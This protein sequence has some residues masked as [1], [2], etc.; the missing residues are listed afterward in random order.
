[1]RSFLPWRVTWVSSRLLAGTLLFLPGWVLAQEAAEKGATTEPDTSDQEAKSAAAET[2]PS[3]TTEPMLWA[4]PR[5]RELLKNEF[6]EYAGVSLSEPERASLF[7]SVLQM[8]KGGALDRTAIKR[9]IDSNSVELTKRAN[10]AAM[11]GSEG[12]GRNPRALDEAANRLIQPL[13]EPPIA[14]NSAFRGLYIANLMAAAPSLLEGHLFT[15]TLA[16][17]VLSRTGSPEVIPILIEQINNPEQ[18]QM[19]K[20]LAAVGLTAATQQGRRLLD[21]NSQSIPAA[22]ALAEL[23]SNDP[24]LPWPVQARALEALGALRQATSQPLNSQPEIAAAAFELLANSDAQPSTRAWAGW[25]LSRMLYSSPQGAVNHELVAWELGQVAA[26]VG[27]SVA[28]IPFAKETPT[29]N[30]RLVA[31]FAEPLLRI[32]D[33]F[34]GEPEVTQSGLNRLVSSPTALRGV[35]QRIRAL[36]AACLQYSQSVGGQVEGARAEVVATL[37]ELKRYLVQN[38]PKQGEF[39][40]GGPKVELP[41]PA[42]AATPKRAGGG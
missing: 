29:R 11:M 18:T 41:E 16:M 37:D 8:A 6:K 36:A 14:A 3:L 28:A 15:R 21:P 40:A 24:S 2:T 35:E 32:L 39:F 12:A 30:L 31:R 4:E 22:R 33:A 20:L 5:R 10:I 1:M 9:H 42:K 23:L 38:P 19:V 26:S 7:N 25:A 13:L 34:A 27:E 17:V